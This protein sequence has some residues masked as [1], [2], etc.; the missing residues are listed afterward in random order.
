VQNNIGVTGIEPLI[1]HHI[2]TL[3]PCNQKE[4]GALI[5]SVFGHKKTAS[6]GG[7]GR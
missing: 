6:S 2:M 3:C 5:N 1:R 4:L 7:I